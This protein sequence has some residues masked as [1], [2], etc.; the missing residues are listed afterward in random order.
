MS[1]AKLVSVALAHI[2]LLQASVVLLSFA[3]GLGG[4][5]SSTPLRHRAHRE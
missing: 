4:L 2:E 1:V 5:F 3:V